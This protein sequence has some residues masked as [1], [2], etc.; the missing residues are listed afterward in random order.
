MKLLMVGFVLLMLGY[1]VSADADDMGACIDE[2]TVQNTYTQ[3]SCVES[4]SD[5]PSGDMTG[6]GC[7]RGPPVTK[8]CCCGPASTTT[9]I[10]STCKGDGCVPLPEFGSMA[11]LAVVM[12]SAPTIAFIVVRKLRN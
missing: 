5:C 10:Q 6:R 4:A 8:H 2:C 9:T 11:A 1:G 7:L 3:Y 12:L